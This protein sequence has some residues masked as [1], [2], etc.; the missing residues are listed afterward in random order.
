[1]IIE[2][3]MATY[4]GEKFLADQLESLLTQTNQEWVLLIHDDGSSDNTISIINQYQANYPRQIIFIHDGIKTG[5]AKNNFAHLLSLASAPYIMFCDQDDV[6]KPDKI[7]MTYACMQIIEAENPDKPVLIHTDLEVVDDALNS[8]SPSMLAYQ[9]LILSP[10]FEQLLVRNS[11]T[12]CTVMLNRKALE[13]SLPIPK[14]AAMHD[15]W[16]GLTVLA[17][18]GI[19]K[20]I[21]SSTVY[22]RQHDGNSIGVQRA[23]IWYYSKKILHFG[24]VLY[25][26]VRVIR[27]AEAIGVYSISKIIKLKFAFTVLHLI[28]SRWLR[29]F[30]R[31][32][33]IFYG[34]G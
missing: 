18:N 8:I 19:I 15:W 34:D 10:S 17:N 4:N 25:S 33:Q 27:Q 2:I 26:I 20:F 9:K 28:P 6:W 29:G 24:S 3:L 22:Y 32:R 12:G 13:L 14:Q 1:M 23:D 30:R 11:I 31:I 5:G 7:Q 16:L 21:N